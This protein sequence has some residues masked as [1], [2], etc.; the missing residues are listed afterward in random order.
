MFYS[1]KE[2][3]KSDKDA[4]KDKDK[5]KNNKGNPGRSLWVTN[6]LP[7]TRAQE[8]KHLL[9]KY[10]KVIGAKVVQSSRYPRQ[11]CYG[12]VTM[13]TRAAADLCIEKLT[14]TELKGQIIRVAKVRPEHSLPI[15]MNK[16]PKKEDSVEKDKR[17]KSPPK[18]S[19]KSDRKSPEKKKETTAA[20]AA[21][22]TTPGATDTAEKKKDAVR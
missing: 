18:S 10:G 16:T 9:S 2:S 1:D 20:T 12:Y 21:A 11:R 7:S 19:T 14:N 3:S 5:D 8:L 13:E 22:P 15:P 17:K 4:E 6:L